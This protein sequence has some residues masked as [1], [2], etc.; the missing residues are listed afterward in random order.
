VTS[1]LAQGLT[2]EGILK[3]CFGDFN[4]SVLDTIECRYACPCTREKTGRVLATLPQDERELLAREDGGAEV[5]CEFCTTAYRFTA[6]ELID[7]T[8]IFGA[9]GEEA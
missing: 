1:M 5:I 9:E 6:E 3:V 4:P 8:L 7:P 2:T